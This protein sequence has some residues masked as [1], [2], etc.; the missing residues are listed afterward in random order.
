MEYTTRCNNCGQSLSFANAVSIDDDG[1]LCCTCECYNVDLDQG[2][3]IFYTP[4]G[5]LCGSLSPGGD[6]GKSWSP[7]EKNRFN[8]CLRLTT[9]THNLWIP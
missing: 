9:M 1:D 2:L 3:A 6:C 8:Q 5:V 7:G 4:N